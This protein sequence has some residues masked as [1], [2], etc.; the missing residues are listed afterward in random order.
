M[1]STGRAKNH[2]DLTPKE[3]FMILHKIGKELLE[4]YLKSKSEKEK[5]GK[6]KIKTDMFFSTCPQLSSVTRKLA[7]E[8]G[9]NFTVTAH[10]AAKKGVENIADFVGGCGSGRLYVGME[11]NGDIKPCVFFP[12]NNE[13]V[14]GNILEGNF[15]SIWN[16]DS[17]F[18]SLRSREKLESYSAS[19][20]IVGCGKC[21]D[22]YI[23]GG[24]RARA[25]GYFIGNLNAPDIGC[26]NNEV[27]WEKR[28]RQPKL[29]T[30]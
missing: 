26:V 21:E 5:T 30:K 20:Q 13:T 10:Y 27:L 29:F 9:S 11:P 7:Q 17:L 25:Y 16:Q 22:K 1:S 14:V 28:K 8:A 3:G 24:C 4:L 18:W 2:L 12:S 6:S 19:G 15:E 23:C